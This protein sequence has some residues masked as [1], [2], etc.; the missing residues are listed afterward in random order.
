V[1]SSSRTEPRRS[2][3]F[4]KLLKTYMAGSFH[5]LSGMARRLADHPT[6]T[7]SRQ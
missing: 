6:M 4:W 5:L 3:I 7:V 2:A 1:A